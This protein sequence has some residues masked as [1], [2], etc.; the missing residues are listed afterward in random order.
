MKA[1]KV[2][3]LYK[4][5]GAVQ[6]LNDLSF[7]VEAG[8]IYGIIGPDGAGKTSLFRI[9]TTLLLADKGTAS[10]DG[11]DVVKDY[12]EIR[13]RI[14]YMPGR[15]SLYQD[16][17]VEENLQF[18]AS[19]FNT[20]IRENYHLIKDIYV[21]IEPFKDRKAGKLSGG[22]KQKLALCCA[23]IH[24][25]SVLFLDEPTTGVDP[26]SRKEFWEMLRKLKEQEITM[27]VSTPYMD[28]ASLC[29][30]IALIQ[31]GRFLQ[32]ATPRQIIDQFE[33]TLWAVQSN[34]MHG[35]IAHLR[36]H[37]QVTSCFAFGEVHHVTVQDTLP[38]DEMKQY[39]HNLG[40]TQIR[41]ETIRPV[42]EDCYM[43][44]AQKQTS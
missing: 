8:Q 13:R 42:I 16:L 39:L 44:L 32:E 3:N 36:S 22:M 28:E 34:N 10:V 7:Q 40:H 23:L 25:P 33:E 31:Q 43:V 30:K 1:V 21:Q 37:P 9:L 20:T 6:A 41:I 19:V 15:F 29:D 14:G 18:F 4:S 38:M 17:S 27:L 24:K 12:K 26:V 11:F 5:Y 2:E 35:L